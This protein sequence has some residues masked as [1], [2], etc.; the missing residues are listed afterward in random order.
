M[1]SATQRALHHIS[2]GVSDLVASAR[3]YDAVLA[4]LGMRRVFEDIRPG[5]RNQAIGYGFE[6]G[7][8]LIA[9]KERG[10]AAAHPGKGF[11]LALGAPSIDAVFAFEAAAVPAGGAV[12]EAAR[13]WPEFGDGYVAA[14]VTDPD[15]W[16]L[17]AVVNQPVTRLATYGTLGPGRPN[18]HHVCAIQGEWTRGSVRGDL[19]QE[20]WGA[21]QGYPG[22]VLDAAGPVVELD[23]LESP[24]LDAHLARLDDFEGIGYRRVPAVVDAAAGR[25][26]AYIYVLAE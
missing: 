14:Y 19:R 25:V 20:G 7:K 17:E 10:D 26:L 13:A 5:Q 6:D 24:E 15:G 18:H 1:T 2:I 16:Q 8:D 9:I 21:D 12:V 3:F 4:T 23:I 22:I 11:H